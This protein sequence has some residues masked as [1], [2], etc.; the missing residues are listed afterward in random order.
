MLS[1]IDEVSK[2][3]VNFQIHFFQILN[4]IVDNSYI[5]YIV[6]YKNKSYTVKF[7]FEE[8]ENIKWD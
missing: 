5:E 6:C 7:E 3:L 8:L 2:R 1:C 4:M